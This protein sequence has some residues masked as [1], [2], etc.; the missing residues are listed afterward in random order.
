M[1]N[2]GNFVWYFVHLVIIPDILSK[3]KLNKLRG[4][5]IKYIGKHNTSNDTPSL[6]FE[7]LIFLNPIYAISLKDLLEK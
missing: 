7:T 4:M 5:H 3:L 2:F 1:T 6:G